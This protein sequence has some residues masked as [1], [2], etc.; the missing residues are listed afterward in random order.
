MLSYVKTHNAD[1]I[2]ENRIFHKLILINYLDKLLPL[3]Q[4]GYFT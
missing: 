3:L 4:L 1:D 2:F